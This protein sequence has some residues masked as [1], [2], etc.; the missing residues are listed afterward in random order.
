MIRAF[1][2]RDLSLLHRLRERSLMLDSQQAF[3]R[4]PQALQNALLDALT[5]GRWACTLVARP[6]KSGEEE[7]IAQVL[8]RSE[9][10]Y[11][12]LALIA[13]G[14]IL[15]KP[16]AIGLLEALVRAAGQQGARNLIA[17]VE[18]DSPAFEGLRRA[19]F[20]I[21]AR[22]RVWRL[23]PGAAPTGRRAAYQTPTSESAVRADD[24]TPWRRENSQ[25]EFPINSLYLN[26]VPALV[27]QAEPPPRRTG[28]GWVHWRQG[29]LLGYL[30]LDRGPL[31]V[32]VQ[33]YFH[34]AAEGVDDLLD[35]FLADFEDRRARSLF[36]CIRSY[37][38]W[39]GSALERLG[40]EPVCDQAVLMKRLAAPV[41]QAVPATLP[42][43]ERSSP[44]PTAP[45]AQAAGA[46]YEGRQPPS[47]SG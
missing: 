16:E 10:T 11:A 44:E 17:E 34:P 3:T 20:A 13:P 25:D 15:E 42:A 4:G 40:F 5:P 23:V 14:S 46:S 43:L 37:Q 2:W 26:L 33:P 38:S 30:N 6:S 7:A 32:W 36:L 39:A 1:D 19:G 8:L 22:Q 35:R 29:E 12:R 27:Q 18:E 41:R 45:F 21:Y 9:D 47:R 31:G 24:P 28:Q